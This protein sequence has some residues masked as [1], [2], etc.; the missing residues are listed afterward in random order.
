MIM[1]SS[2]FDELLC[3]EGDS[4]VTGSLWQPIGPREWGV[5]RF[6]IRFTA[7]TS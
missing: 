7:S 6:F 1:Q 4:A 3:V 2:R 5:A